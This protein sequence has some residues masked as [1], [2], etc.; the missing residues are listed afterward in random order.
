VTVSKPS[1]PTVLP[2]VF[3][4]LF[5]N[6]TPSDRDASLNVSMNGTRIFSSEV[7]WNI[8]DDRSAD[9]QFNSVLGDTI[10]QLSRSQPEWKITGS[11]GLVISEA[12][13]RVIKVNKIELPIFANEIGCL[14]SGTWPVTWLRFLS[15]SRQSDGSFLLMGSDELRG[16]EV[17]MKVTQTQNSERQDDIQSCATLRWGGFLGFFKNKMLICREQTKNGRLLTITGLKDYVV[18]WM[19]QSEQ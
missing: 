6:C 7:V 1:Q 14:L 3:Q 12:K 17:S 10:F 11:D 16:I 2:V 13:N 18:E 9:L 5:L 15:L 4:P 19:V 8:P